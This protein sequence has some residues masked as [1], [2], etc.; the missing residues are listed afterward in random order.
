MPFFTVTVRYKISFAVLKYDYQRDNC[1]NPDLEA[2]SERAAT[3]D[4]V[5]LSD[6]VDK[7]LIFP[8]EGFNRGRCTWDCVL[9]IGENVLEVSAEIRI[10][11]VHL[12]AHFGDVTLDIVEFIAS[13]ER[14][15]PIVNVVKR[16]VS[17]LS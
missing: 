12:T 5:V 15:K 10:L 14:I 17:I 1:H 9:A 6:L 8:K 3:T 4:I 16:K 7:V 13:S 2:W 11:L